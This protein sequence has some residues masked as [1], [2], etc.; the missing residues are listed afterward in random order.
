MPERI[1]PDKNK[2]WMTPPSQSIQK[3]KKG[4]EKSRKLTP[5]ASKFIL[6][7][8]LAIYCKKFLAV[9]TDRR[10]TAL[11]D[12][13]QILQD[14]YAFKKM[15]H[16]LGQEDQSHSPKFTLQLSELWH[17]L[18]EDQSLIQA[19]E[20]EQPQITPKINALIEAMNNYPPNE[21]H[22]LGFYLTQYVGA[23]WLPFPF[24]DLLQKLHLEYQESPATSILSNWLA[25][26][27]SAIS[28]ISSK[29]SQ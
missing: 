20:E 18:L 7:A 28:A 17:H 23:K 21:E 11:V 6:F 2:E 24:M 10:R 8:T 29:P 15:L 14:L 4:K 12:L 9:F 25:L 22:N 26:L 16:N 1:E 19:L 13:Q 27:D 5:E 3:D